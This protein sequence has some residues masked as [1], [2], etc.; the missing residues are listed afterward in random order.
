MALGLLGTKLGMTTI[1]DDKGVAHAVTIIQA[2]PCYVTQVKTPETDGYTALQLGYGQAKAKRT[3]QPEMGHLK[4]AGV[5]PLRHLVE[6]RVD[7][8]ANFQVG[9]VLGADLF[10]AG[11]VVDVAGRSIGQGFTGIVA[12]YKTG[13]GPMSHGSKFHRHPGSIGAGT[14]PSR[15]YK[16]VKMPGRKG[17]KRA[18]VKFLTIIKVD[19]ERNILAIKGAVPGAENGLVEIRP[20]VRVGAKAGK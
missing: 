8:T 5:Q 14:T 20:A 2:G 17:A 1:Y 3:N 16:G 13:R 15:V 7:T 9:Q 19:A 6:F 18:T 11:D 4:K 10:K 12:R